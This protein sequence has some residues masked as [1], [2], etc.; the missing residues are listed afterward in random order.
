MPERPWTTRAVAVLQE[1]QTYIG[2]GLLTHPL[3]DLVEDLR[4]RIARLLQEA[5]TS[6]QEDTP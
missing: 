2:A 5:E 3:P 6:G 1:V 4:D